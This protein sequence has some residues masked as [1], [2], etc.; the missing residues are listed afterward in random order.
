MKKRILIIAS[1][2]LLLLSECCF[3][4]FAGYKKPTQRFFVNDFADV[5][6]QE[7]ENEIYSRAL[8]LESKTTAQV[9]VVTVDTLD[10]E[11]AADYAM[12]IGR[13]WGVGTK[14]DNNGVVIL[15]SKSDRE[16]YIAVGYGLEGALNDSKVGRIIDVYG[17]DYLSVN[18]FSKGLTSISKAVVN[19]V[20]T[21]YGLEPEEG[22]TK[23]DELSDDVF[24]YNSDYSELLASVIVILIAIIISFLR[25]KKGGTTIFF[26]GGSGH[27]GGFFGGSSGG[28]SG[29][30]G[31]GSFGGGGAG[32]GF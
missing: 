19:E 26:G 4:S 5:I 12:G 9:V 27:G 17:M 6:S 20:Y 32:R 31:G 25:R 15:L 2:F 18:N 14:K 13:E 24:S 16:I 7:D 21:E 23:I 30:G 28:S 11:A 1:V 3:Y 8:S 10:G 29:G 22:Y